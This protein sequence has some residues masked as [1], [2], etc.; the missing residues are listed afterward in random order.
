MFESLKNRM[1]IEEN[2][3]YNSEAL[4]LMCENYEIDDA[5]DSIVL[6]DAPV[7][8]EDDDDIERIIEEIDDDD[9]SDPD[10]MELEQKLCCKED[11]QPLTDAV[12][13]TDDDVSEDAMLWW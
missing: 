12:E 7:S 9:D 4:S 2:K 8:Y 5:M 6:E 10:G 13:D 1:S 11:N 3:R